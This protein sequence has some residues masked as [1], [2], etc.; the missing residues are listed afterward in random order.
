MPSSSLHPPEPITYLI[1]SL[2]PGTGGEVYAH[3]LYEFLDRR[4]RVQEYLPI[5]KMIHET[6][7]RLGPYFRRLVYLGW[8][9]DLLISLGLACRFRKLRGVLVEDQYHSFILLAT[10]VVHRWLRRGRIITLVHHI[11]NYA[12]DAPPSWRNWLWKWRER[13]ALG[14][15]DALVTVSEYTKGEIVSL[16]IREDK[17]MILPPGLDR[18]RMGGSAGEHGT[19][20]LCVAHIVPRK[21]ILHLMEAFALLNSEKSRLHLAGSLDL[22]PA[23]VTRIRTLVEE[24]CMT[25]R[26]IFH[27]RVGQT[28]LSR[29]FSEAG[30]FV[31][32]SLQEGF[33][34]TLLEAMHYG[35]PI[36]ASNL[37][38]IPELVHEGVNGLLVPPGE[39]KPLADA[40][41]GLLDDPELR[42]TLGRRGRQ[43]VENRFH[44]ETTCENFADLVD[45]PSVR[46]GVTK[47]TLPGERKPQIP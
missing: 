4:G 45:Q 13:L 3:K 33:G 25:D 21:G 15:S 8:F 20:L 38:A 10:N 14:R 44:W 24:R 7:L 46:T 17:I 2:P 5:D 23:Y 26:V 18:E 34:I 9:G 22:D 35:L 19:D 16:G 43:L 32:P 36:V 1:S 40:I 6:R 39:A 12:S 37:S 41:Q 30:I 31:F 28:E 27:G 42:R 11:E 47:T 29:L